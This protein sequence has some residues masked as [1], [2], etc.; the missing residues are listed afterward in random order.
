MYSCSIEIYQ[1]LTLQVD[2]QHQKFTS[3][4]LKFRSF[5]PPQ[6]TTPPEI[7]FWTGYCNLCQN[8]DINSGSKYISIGKHPSVVVALWNI[9]SYVVAACLAA[10]TSQ[11]TAYPTLEGRPARRCEEPAFPMYTTFYKH[12]RLHYFHPQFHKQQKKLVIVK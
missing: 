4:N 12:T 9:S 11:Y 6:R 1:L 5:I 3:L 2:K 7:F 10:A 8:C